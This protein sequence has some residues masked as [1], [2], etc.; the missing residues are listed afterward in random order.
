MF[1]PPG[2]AGKRCDAWSW[3]A[4]ARR[5]PPFQTIVRTFL[6]PPP[7]PAGNR[8]GFQTIAL[9]GLCFVV[10]GVCW[11]LESNEEASKP[12]REVLPPDVVKALPGGRVLMRD[13]SIR[14]D[15]RP[16]GEKS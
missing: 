10:L 8:I 9:W 13:G 15:P 2:P 3:R 6:I 11:K 1:T 7:G 12:K 4:P 14:H 5:G 16:A